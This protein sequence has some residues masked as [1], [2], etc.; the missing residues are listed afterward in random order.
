[1]SKKN[2]GGAQKLD[3][4]IQAILN[5]SESTA[6]SGGDSP[7]VE[8]AP[9]TI[10]TLE[11][12]DGEFSPEYTNLAHTKQWGILVSKAES[13]ISAGSDVEARLWWIRGHLGALSLP[14]SLLAA[15]FETVCR[16]LVSD[17]KVADLYKPLVVEIGQIMRERLRG[18]GDR[19]QEHAVMLALHQ[20]GLDESK[21]VERPSWGRVP[22]VAPR[23]E[24]GEPAQGEKAPASESVSVKPG[25]KPVTIFV[26]ALLVLAL[27]ALVGRILQRQLSGAAVYVASEAMV[28][29]QTAAVLKPPLV[30][31]RAALSNLGALYYSL[32]ETG[33]AIPENKD[34]PA[35][36]NPPTTTQ[37]PIPARQPDSKVAAVEK[38]AAGR[39]DVVNTD[40]PV[41]GQEFRRGIER[42]VSQQARLPEPGYELQPKPIP[43][44]G[45]PEVG[46][47]LLGEVKSVLVPTNV[48]DSPSYRARIIAK[49]KEGDKVSVEARVGRWVRIR[50]KRGKT[51]YVFA[52]DV[53]E[54][55]DF[56]SP[57]TP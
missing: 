7:R 13:A 27:G 56:R 30:E 54:L 41:E 22:S 44:S 29:T 33:T 24:L 10:F 35:E 52:Q 8:T 2:G 36:P 34:R 4:G 43:S 11:D 9:T 53:G 40:G 23:F 55:E 18:V 45:Y 50:S 16:Q 47:V 1:M 49:L 57:G 26:V 39:K 37:Q 15:P 12:A 25:R 48:L 46:G 21:E 3:L 28:A 6:N 31:P 51:G 32:S 42:G 5:R 17:Q 19:R 14:V 38:P 20:L